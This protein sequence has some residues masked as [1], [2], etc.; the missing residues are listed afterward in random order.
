[1]PAVGRGGEA[2]VAPAARA[3]ATPRSAQPREPSRR[4]EPLSTTS[5]SSGARVCARARRAAPGSQRRPFQFGTTTATRSDHGAPSAARAAARAARLARRARSPRGVGDDGAHPA[6][7][8]ARRRSA[9]RCAR[10][11]R[12]STRQRVEARDRRGER[13]GRRARRRTCPSRP[14]STV[15]RAPPS[16][17]A[18]TGRPAACAST[19]AIPNSS[20]AVTT[21]ARARARRAGDLRVG[22]AAGEAHR[23]PGEPPQPPRVGPVADDD[24]RQAEPR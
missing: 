23:R 18:M 7:E 6:A 4:V 2:G 9:R 11:S 20:V 15:S 1:M 10:T 8:V 14:R 13:L 24:Q 5:T 3:R 12:G 17:S 21:S 16:R 19:A 22:D